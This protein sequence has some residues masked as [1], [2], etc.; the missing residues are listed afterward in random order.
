M[1]GER[2]VRI[3]MLVD[4]H[5][6]QT[7]D[8]RHGRALLR[9]ELEKGSFIVDDEARQ[10]AKIEDLNEDSVVTVYPKVQGG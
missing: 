6:V 3:R 5:T 2:R 9:K 8:L 1:G 7:Y 4:G 10:L